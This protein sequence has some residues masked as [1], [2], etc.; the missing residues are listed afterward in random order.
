[1]IDLRKEYGKR[2]RISWDE[3]YDPKGI[4][5]K[6]QDIAYMEIPCKAGIIYP[7]K[8]N[9][10]AICI[11]YKR[12]ATRQMIEA[13]FDMVQSGDFERTF[14]FDSDRFEEVVA[15]VQPKRKRQHQMSEMN[16][17][18]AAERMKLWHKQKKDYK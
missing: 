3:S 16:K 5:K 11:D 15:I 2:F 12:K 4:P 18:K 8:D 6:N 10:L 1:M 13:G 9:T 17:Q 14:L 7:F